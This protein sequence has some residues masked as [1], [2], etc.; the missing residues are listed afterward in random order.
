MPIA[1]KVPGGL[2]SA[3]VASYV[4]SEVTSLSHSGLLFSTIAFSVGA[5]TKCSSGCTAEVVLQKL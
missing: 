1:D 2:A 5:F 4:S 3:S